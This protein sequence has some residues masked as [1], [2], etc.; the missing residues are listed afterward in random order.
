MAK[1]FEY[2]VIG[3]GLIG[4]AAAKYLANGGASVAAVGPQI[5]PS[6]SYSTLFNSHDDQTRIYR[7]LDDDGQWA[8]WAR[9]SVE[10]YSL[11]EAESGISFATKADC[12]IIR[13]TPRSFDRMDT[14]ARKNR[15]E[16]RALDEGEIRHLLDGVAHE[17]VHSLEARIE[18]KLAGILNPRRLLEAQQLLAKRY[19]ATFIDAIATEI[20]FGAG[21]VEV[22]T[23]VGK[24]RFRKV[25]S[26]T[27]LYSAFSHIMPPAKTLGR[28]MT[29]FEVS[30][31]SL[32]RFRLRHPVIFQAKGFDVYIV[33]PTLHPNNKYYLK[34]GGDP[35]DYELQSSS[36]VADWFRSAGRPVVSEFHQNALRIVFPAFQLT[37]AW[38][39][40]CAVSQTVSGRP[41]LGSGLINNTWGFT[42]CSGSAAK[43]SD[44]IGRH[45]A[46]I[47]TQDNA[48]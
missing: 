16:H 36:D 20:E 27:G 45:A 44:E 22:V 6:H 41:Y 35:N 11:I 48:R 47:I 14:I 32:D 31:S 29:F 12:L 17:T 28:T 7:T 3:C 13:D 21:G 5:Q 38:T 10:R 43:G 37:P 2:G 42:G 24:F 8:N 4:S 46:S 34:I 1:S 15:T 18:T 39:K 9:A 30:Q 19:G 40:P 33:P 25:V 23:S 26:C